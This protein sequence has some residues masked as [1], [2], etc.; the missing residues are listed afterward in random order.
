MITKEKLMDKITRNYKVTASGLLSID[1]AG[2]IWISLEDKGDV[3]LAALLMDFHDKGVKLNC[4]YDEDYEGPK[5]DLE[6]GEIL[7]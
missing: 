2:Q 7:E 1:D 3:S 4:S 6:T 5:A